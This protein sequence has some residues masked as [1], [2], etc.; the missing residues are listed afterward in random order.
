MIAEFFAGAG[1]LLRGFAVWRRHPTRMALGLL[2]A[3]LAL[4]LLAAAAVPFFLSVGA[5]VEAMT[6]F[7]EEWLGLWRELLRGTLSA[8][9]ILAALV[10][11][12][13][14]F[15]A[16][17]LVLGE[18]FYER[19][20]RAV[21]EDLGEAVPADG[22]RFWTV[23]G[24]AVRLILLGVLVAVAVFVLGFVPVVGGVAA[25]VLGL[26]LTGRLLARELTARSFDAR[27][28]DPQERAQLYAAGRARVLGFG[29]A[30]QLC[31]LVP[32]G[33][34]ATMPAAVAGATLLARDLRQRAGDAAVVAVPAPR[35]A[36]TDA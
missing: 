3:L 25:G 33:T 21:E 10:L 14:V 26:V 20:W 29:I 18:P 6:P 12:S 13:M 15:T 19:I 28:L 7:A 23:L 24:E 32:L 30:T 36:P 1:A 27:D 17:T 31:F 35:E 22:G 5:I 9:L 16:L 11:S 4:L 2:P 8:I 34:I